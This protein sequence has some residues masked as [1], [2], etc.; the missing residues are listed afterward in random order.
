MAV[1]LDAGG[2]VHVALA[3]GQ[4]LDQQP[5][6]GVDALADINHRLTVGGRETRVGGEGHGD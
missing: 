6:D 1:G 2:G 4:N 3:L 5:I